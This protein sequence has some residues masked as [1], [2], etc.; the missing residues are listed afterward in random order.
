MANENFSER[1][2]IPSQPF[3]TS[4]PPRFSQLKETAKDAIAWELDQFFSYKTN[5]ALA[6]ISEV[7]NIQKF[8]LGAT[9]QEN[10]LET[11]VNTIMAYGDTPD[12]FPMISITSTSERERKMNIGSNFVTA[13][14]YAPSIVGTQ[15]GPFDFSTGIPD[16]QRYLTL[17][18]T[19]WP[20][21]TVNSATASTI[22]FSELIFSDWSNVTM[23]QVVEQ[24]NKSQALYYNLEKT[25]EGYLRISTGGPCALSSPNYIEVT[26][27]DTV[28]LNLLGFTLGQSDT[29]L[30]S[31]NPPK[32]RYSLAADMSISIDVVSDDLNTRTE[33]ADLVY[34]YF[35]FYM[36][37]RRFQLFGRS[38]F[39]RD[40]DPEEWFH[41]S[42]NNQ[43]SWSGEVTTS[44]QGGEQY[45]KIYAVRGTIPIFIEDFIDRDIVDEPVFLQRDYINPADASFPDGDYFGINYLK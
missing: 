7:P 19:T 34:N 28:L 10:S 42:F 8:A 26:G 38:Y 33:L 22:A 20:D 5:D 9:T 12:A 4:D 13:V 17:E 45:E 16:G 37:K 30:N 39:S 24:I 14:Q 40:Q 43:F 2:Y 36:E 11:V 41:I 6:K 29:Y 18:I 35:T 25:T 44:R 32:N 23:D 31:S 27:G 21:G 1:V 15:T 3:D